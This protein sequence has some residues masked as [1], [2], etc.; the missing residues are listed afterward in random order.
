MK[1]INDSK[2][3]Y[4]IKQYYSILRQHILNE[5]DPTQHYQHFSINFPNKP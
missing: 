1:Y 2:K 4:K 5:E 3:I